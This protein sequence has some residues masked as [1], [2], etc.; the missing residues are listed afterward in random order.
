MPPELRLGSEAFEDGIEGGLARIVEEGDGVE[1]VRPGGGGI[2]GE[3]EEAG[4]PAHRVHEAGEGAGEFDAAGGGRGRV[5][6]GGLQGGES[7]GMA[8]EG[9]E[10]R[11]GGRRSHAVAEVDGE[12]FGDGDE[13]G[14]AEAGELGPERGL[15]KGSLLEAAQGLVELAFDGTGLRKQEGEGGGKHPVGIEHEFPRNPPAGSS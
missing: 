12:A 11:G 1:T 6:E 5:A 9:G 10:Q 2:G 14:G 4:A 8:L 15:L 13:G 7:G 3:G